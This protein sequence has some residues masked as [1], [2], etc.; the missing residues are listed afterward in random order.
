MA[1]S[2]LRSRH[3]H[4]S[5][6][7]SFVT[8]LPVRDRS[9]RTQVTALQCTHGVGSNTINTVRALISNLRLILTSPTFTVLGL[10]P[11]QFP[12]RLHFFSITNRQ[13]QTLFKPNPSTTSVPRNLKLRRHVLEV[14]SFCRCCARD[15][16]PSLGACCRRTCTSFILL[17]EHS[18]NR[19]CFAGS[20]RER[21][22]CQQA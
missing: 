5:G 16:T 17:F 20:R 9:D 11:N 1:S 19:G 14:A 10:R 4:S 18:P 12:L 2:F 6:E 8:R 3:I 21:T 13:R 7:F 22:H 15:R